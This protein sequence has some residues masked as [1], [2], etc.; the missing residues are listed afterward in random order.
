VMLSG[1]ASPDL[2]GYEFDAGSQPKLATDVTMTVKRSAIYEEI[3]NERRRQD[4]QWGGPEHDDNNNVR[5][6]VTF[7]VAYL[8]KAVNRNSDWGRK[9][10]I[11]RVAL[12]KVAALCVAAVEAFDRR[13]ASGEL[14]E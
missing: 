1:G 4:E 9:L 5:D 3:E 10:S 13:V 8:G 11:S 7:I 2:E 14:V 6:W 12:I